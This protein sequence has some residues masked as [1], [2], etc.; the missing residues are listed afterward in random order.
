[1]SKLTI[2]LTADQQK[3]I[4]EKTGKNISQLNIDLAGTGNLSAEDLE[5][6]A[7]GH[8]AQNVKV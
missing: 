3:Q 2:H 7:G 1:M 6:V 8:I 5:K 4:K